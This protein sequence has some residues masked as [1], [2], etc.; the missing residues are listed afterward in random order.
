MPNTAFDLLNIFSVK[1]SL[2]SLFLT[3][4]MRY[5]CGREMGHS[6]TSVS[7]IY[8]RSICRTLTICCFVVSDFWP[9]WPFEVFPPAPQK[10]LKKPRSAVRIRVLKQYL[11]K[12]CVVRWNVSNYTYPYSCWKIRFYL[13]HARTFMPHNYFYEKN[14]LWNKNKT[15][16]ENAQHE[17]VRD[18]FLFAFV[19]NSTFVFNLFVL[20]CTTRLT[21][22]ENS[23][24]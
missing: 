19:W 17:F 12:K 3:C 9:F 2:R 6:G 16:I 20:H 15:N 13:V 10:K 5:T 18:F 1:K 24:A 11:G 4:K 14:Q 7:C 22:P 8:E 23:T 21:T